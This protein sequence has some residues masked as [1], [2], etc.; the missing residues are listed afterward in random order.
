MPA[1]RRHKKE[2]GIGE[3]H[4]LLSLVVLGVLWSGYAY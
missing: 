2:H 1:D 3:D 4:T